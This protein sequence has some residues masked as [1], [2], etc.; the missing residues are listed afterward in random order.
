MSERALE[1]LIPGDLQ[2]ATGG[3]VYDRTMAD[4]LRERGWR[5]RVHAHAER[6]IADL[7]DHAC[8]LVDGLALGATAQLLRSH[9]RRL[10]LVALMHM[11]AA[12]A[13]EEQALHLMRHIIVT[14]RATQKALAGCGV[15][16]ARLSVVEPGIWPAPAA[17]G[18][19]DRADEDIVRMLCVA[20]VHEGKGHEL[21]IAALAP[22]AHLPWHLQCVGSVSRSPATVQRLNGRLRATGLLDRIALLGER[23]HASLGELYR[24]ADLFVLPTLR[25]SYGMAVA[26]ALAH[27]LPVISSRTGAIPDLVGTAGILIE[28]GDG[29]ALH[30]ALRRIL[31]DRGLRS[32]LRAEA[33]TAGSRLTP[34]PDACER[35]A[36][37]LN[38]IREQATAERAERRL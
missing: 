6:V 1:F 33:R 32:S 28:P 37:V 22:L 23:P 26:E 12:S 15:D 7:P 36:R 16:A 29:E 9:S 17:P 38:R 3:Y 10:T 25:E 4:G 18:R 19:P 35:M 20:T 24:A 14:G 13:Q 8:V 5:V 27:G 31:E 34:W 2:S 30:A 11:P 21:L